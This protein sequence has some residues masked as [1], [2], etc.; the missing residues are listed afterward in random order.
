MDNHPS[1]NRDN[2]I[3]SILICIYLFTYLFW[4]YSTGRTASTMLCRNSKRRHLRLLSNFRGKIFSL[5]SL[6]IM[7][8]VGILEM[9]F[10]RLRKFFFLPNLLVHE[11]VLNFVKC[12]FCLCWDDYKD[13]LPCPLTQRIPRIHFWILK[14][15]CNPRINS[16]SLWCVLFF[17]YCWTHLASAFLGLS[18]WSFIFL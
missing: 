1:R 6:G 18:A 10:I 12:Y 11:L 7:L 15:P 8:S 3:S 9:T 4:P 5:S 13:F 16:S 17:R 2:F 14:Q